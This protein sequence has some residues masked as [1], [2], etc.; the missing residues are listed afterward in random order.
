MGMVSS[1]TGSEGFETGV[2]P[3]EATSAI[4]AVLDVWFWGTEN[5]WSRCSAV[6]EMTDCTP[7]RVAL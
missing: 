6:G 1:G 3:L 2:G 4:V 7:G 5:E